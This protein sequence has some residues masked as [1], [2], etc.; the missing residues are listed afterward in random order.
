MTKRTRY[1]LLSVFGSLVLGL[2]LIYEV[3]STE[4]VRAA[5]RAYGELMALGNRIDFSEAERLA[6]ARTLCSRRFIAS[7]RLTA[8]PEGGIAGL[9]RT[10]NKNFQAWREGPNVWICP[11]N[12]IGPL[13]QFVH[14]DGHW[15]FDGLVGILRPGGEVVKATELPDIGAD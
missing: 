14:E 10:I 9:P 2:V 6:A 15:R 4:S 3:I 8:G 1:I 13:Y 7:G 11:T 12:R 5:V